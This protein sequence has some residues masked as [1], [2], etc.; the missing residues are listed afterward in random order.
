MN[1]KNNIKSK[2]IQTVRHNPDQDSCFYIG[3][4]VNKAKVLELHKESLRQRNHSDDQSEPD[5]EGLLSS[6][7]NQNFVSTNGPPPY[8]Q[9][10]SLLSGNMMQRDLVNSYVNLFISHFIHIHNSRCHLKLGFL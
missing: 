10:E 4:S 3:P 6:S 1:L 7:E 8:R 5:D 2:Q 9:N